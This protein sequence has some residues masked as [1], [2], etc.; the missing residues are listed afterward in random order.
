MAMKTYGVAAILVASGCA[1]GACSSGE[2]GDASRTLELSLEGEGENM[3]LSSAPGNPLYTATYP[4]IQNLKKMVVTTDR[5]GSINSTCIAQDDKIVECE[6]TTFFATTVKSNDQ[7]TVTIYDLNGE[8][9][10]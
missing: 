5:H 6:D 2:S 3:R 7:T 10:G 1:I 8:P 9:C 4:N